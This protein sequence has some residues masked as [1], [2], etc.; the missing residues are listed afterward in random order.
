MTID[1]LKRNV[2]RGQAAEIL[3]EQKYVASGFRIMERN[4]RWPKMG[5]IDLIARAG[6]RYYF[7][8][9]KSAPTLEMAA[10]HLTSF[11]RARMHDMAQRYLAARNLAATTDMRFD[12]AL[13]DYF[14]SVR[15]LPGALN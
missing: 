12:A 15:V 1:R 7:V 6:S 9:C 10:S 11:Q 4:F 2:A 8:E 3:I 13:V 14:G 5:E